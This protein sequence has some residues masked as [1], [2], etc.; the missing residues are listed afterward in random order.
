MFVKITKPGK[1][2]LFDICAL[3]VLGNIPAMSSTF[4][5]PVYMFEPMRVLL[6]LAIA[7][8][9]RKNAYVLSV[10]FPLFSFVTASH[11]SLIKSGLLGIEMLLNLWIFYYLTGK[12][13]DVFI[14]SIAA[15]FIAKTVYYSLKFS[16]LSTG[17][18]TGSLMATPAGYQLAIL[19]LVSGYLKLLSLK[20]MV[21]T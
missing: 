14:A 7:H 13:K 21:S 20:A 4:S 8:T 19:I 10:L 6:Y 15:I 3:L 18:M 11:P 12:K 17:A 1:Y 5:F 16:A 2:I 9:N